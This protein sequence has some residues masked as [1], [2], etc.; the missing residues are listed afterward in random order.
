M[1]MHKTIDDNRPTSRLAASAV[2]AA[3][4]A[5]RAALNLLAAF[6]GRASVSCSECIP[7]LLEWSGAPA[8]D[9]SPFRGAGANFSRMTP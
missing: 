9:G 3:P 7:S 2:F 6:N 5:P 4:Q 1:K 8:S